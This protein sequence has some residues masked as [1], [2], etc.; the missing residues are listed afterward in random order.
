MLSWNLWGKAFRVRK[1]QNTWKEERMDGSKCLLVLN[2]LHG[3]LASNSTTVVIM[4]DIG[5]TL[6]ASLVV[7]GL[8]T[9]RNTMA[10]SKSEDTGTKQAEITWASS[11]FSD[12]QDLVHPRLK[13]APGGLIYWSKKLLCKTRHENEETILESMKNYRQ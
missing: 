8:I 12:P 6:L 4:K 5:K 10:N 7:L 11:P 1:S 3:R 13:R 9:V 2:Q